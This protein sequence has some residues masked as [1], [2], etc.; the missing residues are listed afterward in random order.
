[1]KIKLKRY[2]LIKCIEC[3]KKF[4]WDRINPKSC[5]C[6]SKWGIYKGHNVG[7]FDTKMETFY[8]RSK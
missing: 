1:M 2:Y 3:K 8:A 4:K 6:G 7:L 5:L